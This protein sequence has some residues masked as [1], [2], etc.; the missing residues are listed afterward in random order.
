MLVFTVQP[1]S[2]L[3]RGKPPA[4]RSPWE[5]P[6]AFGKIKLVDQ[7]S[8]YSFPPSPPFASGTGSMKSFLSGR[9]PLS[10]ITDAFSFFKPT[11]F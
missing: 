3:S 8:D 9:F 5:L 10:G 6:G 11:A 1:P 7:I 4:M 2:S